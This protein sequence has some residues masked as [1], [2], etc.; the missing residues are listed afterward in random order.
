MR[1][2]PDGRPTGGD[3]PPERN[4]GA[5]PP[6]GDDDRGPVG[7][8]PSWGALYA[9]VVVYALLLITVLYV[10]SVTLDFSGGS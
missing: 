8:F 2:A 4:L 6:G 10:L 5:R 1:E 3:A 7:I 9:T